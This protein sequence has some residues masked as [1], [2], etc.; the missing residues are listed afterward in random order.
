[1]LLWA[2]KLVNWIRAKVELEDIKAGAKK[3]R[4]FTQRTAVASVPGANAFR[5]LDDT[6]YDPSRA[7]EMLS[8]RKKTKRG[9]TVHMDGAV[10]NAPGSSAYV[11]SKNPTD[12]QLNFVQR[13]QTNA[14]TPVNANPQNDVT[15]GEP[16]KREPEK[17][18]R[19]QSRPRKK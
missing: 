16:K 6:D 7:Q 15:P 19:E 9:D 14:Y 10:A 3:G 17:S 4:T 11:I 1:M 18:L 8:Y 13:L 2:K 5:T 12:A